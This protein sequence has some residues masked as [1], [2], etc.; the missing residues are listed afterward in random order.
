[1]IFYQNYLVD[2]LSSFKIYNWLSLT[3]GSSYS[4]RESGAKFKFLQNWLC[5]G[6]LSRDSSRFLTVKFFV[7]GNPGIIIIIDSY[8]SSMESRTVTNVHLRTL[9][10]VVLF[11]WHQ[12]FLCLSS[13][14]KTV[15]RNVIKDTKN[16]LKYKVLQYAGYS[17]IYWFLV[18]CRYWSCGAK[19]FQVF[20]LRWNVCGFLITTLVL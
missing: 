20:H 5:L 18:A 7:P 9:C 1:M 12:I 2:R 16:A 17:A 4:N 8:S 10:W 11:A 14:L 6:F 3:D 13:S 15:L 19:K